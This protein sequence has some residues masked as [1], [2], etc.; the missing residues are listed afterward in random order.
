MQKKTTTHQ[1][2]KGQ[3]DPF[4]EGM[5]P[6]TPTKVGYH[7]LEIP[8]LK[9]DPEDVIPAHSLRIV[10]NF[11][12]NGEVHK[13][14]PNPNWKITRKGNPCHLENVGDEMSW[15]LDDLFLYVRA[16]NPGSNVPV[17]GLIIY[18]SVKKAKAGDTVVTND[19]FET[20]FST[21]L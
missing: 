6:D 9:A 2:V 3:S 4:I 8:T 13:M 21:I 11:G 20:T 19:R 12:I 16:I 15:N 10:L 14:M 17:S 7:I 1:V 5:L 18:E